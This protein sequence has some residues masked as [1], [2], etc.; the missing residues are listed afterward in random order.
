M[1]VLRAR[2]YEAELE[3]QQA[4]LGAQRRSQIGIGRPLGE[5]PHLQLPAGP[6]HRSPHRPDRA[7]HPR[8]SWP[9]RSTSSSTGS[10]PP[11]A[12]SGSRRS[13]PASD[14][15]GTRTWPSRRGRSKRRSTGRQAYLAE[16]GDEH[17]RRSRRVAAV[18]GD[19]PVARRALRVPRPPAHAR[20]ARVASRRRA[21]AARRASRCSTSPA[22]WP[23]ATSWSRCARACSSRGPRP[24]CSW[25]RRSRRSASASEPLVADL[26]TGSGCVALSIA[27]RARGRAGVGDRPLAASRSRS[28]PRTPSASG[29]AERVTVLEGDLLGRLPP[30]LRGRARRRRGEPAL[31]PER[32]PARRCRPRS[33]AS[34]RTSRSTAAPT[35]STCSGGSLREARDWLRPAGVLAVELDESTGRRRRPKKR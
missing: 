9:A 7:Q 30:E 6:R 14:G 26:C 27:Q 4:E 23:S 24:R 10:P 18:G 34:S 2:L 19:R 15:Q 17:P 32:R 12:P 8:R 35:V 5:D 33:P 3:R 25:T 20:G 21:S 22:R 1:R 13:P 16:K 31:H 29:L 28:P 11:T